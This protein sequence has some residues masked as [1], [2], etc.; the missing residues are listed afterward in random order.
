MKKYISGVISRRW[1]HFGEHPARSLAIFAVVTGVVWVIQT[2]LC[3]KILP[4]DAIEAIVWGEKMQLGVMKSPPLSGY[5]AYGFAWLSGYSDWALY[6]AAELSRVIGVYFTYRLAREFFDETGAATSALLLYFLYYY[7]PPSMKFCSHDTQI[8]L[9]P[10]VGWFFWKSLRYNRI[11]DWLGLA[12]F[13]ALATW[14]KYA[15]PQVLAGCFVY[16]L[17]SPETRK[18]FAAPGPYLAGVVYV[19]LLSPHLYWLVR[20]DF[21]PLRHVGGRLYEAGHSLWLEPLLAILTMLMP[22]ALLGALLLLAH[23]PWKMPW[24]IRSTDFGGIRQ[25]PARKDALVFSLA[26]TVIPEMFYLLPVFGGWSIILMWFSYLA[27]FTGITVVAAM[28]WPCSR[29]VFRNLLAAAW[30][31][32]LILLIAVTIDVL[33]KPRYRIHTTPDQVVVPAEAFFRQHSGGRPIPVVYGERWLA[34]VVQNYLAYRP[35][36]C[37]EED[38]CD[39]ELYGDRIR[40]E[41]ALVIYNSGKDVAAFAKSIGYPRMKIQEIRY[42]YYAQF[43]RSRKDRLGFGFLPPGVLPENFVVHWRKAKNHRPV[44][45]PA[46]SPSPG[47]SAK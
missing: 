8:A 37:T 5:I 28:P 19:A 13:A 29:R 6:L 9:L 31:Y 14:G 45:I 43:G 10:A 25:E 41:G 40:K 35:P 23:L 18:R 33:A 17:V 20:H 15:A 36:V 34:G 39:M 27:S 46:G 16:M 11:T 21:L 12:F 42:N 4:M 30:V 47:V 7:M 44:G 38:D 3:Q 24:S 22:Y 26:L 32:F 2:S 1:E